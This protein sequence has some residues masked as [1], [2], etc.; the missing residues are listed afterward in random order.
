[1]IDK[2]CKRGKRLK[3]RNGGN[4]V[5]VGANRWPMAACGGQCMCLA[6]GAGESDEGCWNV[7]G[8]GESDGE[9]GEK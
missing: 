5:K 4:L 9:R 6:V 3:L 8:A 2:M 1:V 7:L